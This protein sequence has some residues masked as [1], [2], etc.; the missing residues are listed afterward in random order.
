MIDGE[1]CFAYYLHP[2]FFMIDKKPFIGYNTGSR[3][4]IHYLLIIWKIK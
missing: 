3:L 4:F 1:G 2:A